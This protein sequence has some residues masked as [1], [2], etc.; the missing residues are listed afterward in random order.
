MENNKGIVFVDGI[1]LETTKTQFA[2]HNVI[3]VEVGTTGWHGKS[4]EGSRTYFSI[5][6]CG[7]TDMTARIS[8]SSCG[9]TGQVEIMF[10][11]DA[12]LSTFM[13]ALRFALDVLEKKTA[14]K[15]DSGKKI[16]DCI[17]EELRQADAAK[18]S[19]I[20]WSFMKYLKEL[21]NLFGADFTTQHP[22]LISAAVIA[23]EIA[24]L[25][26]EMTQL[27]IAITDKP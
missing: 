13:Q 14:S 12:E 21:S 1:R 23:D 24:A 22:E 15:E 2:S 10:G 27:Q 19:D 18:D 26:L 5:K 4:S 20:L 7:G 11:G 6:D 9:E 17:T 25:R 16:V 3:E 8:G